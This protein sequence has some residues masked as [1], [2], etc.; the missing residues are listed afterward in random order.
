MT[1]VSQQM[2][3]AVRVW[4][5]GVVSPRGFSDLRISSGFFGQIGVMSFPDTELLP[6]ASNELHDVV[7]RIVV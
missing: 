1:H 5:A 6:F 3:V 4:I 7:P 2:R